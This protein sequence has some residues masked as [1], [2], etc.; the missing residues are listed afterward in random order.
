[1]RACNLGVSWL[2]ITW[3]GNCTLDIWVTT[4]MQTVS[5]LSLFNSR[6]FRYRRKTDVLLQR[7]SLLK[8]AVQLHHVTPTTW[9]S[10]IVSRCGRV[11]HVFV[12]SF[13]CLF[14]LRSWPLS[15]C[16]VRFHS[17]LL[18]LRSSSHH[19]KHLGEAF[20][21]WHRIIAPCP[22]HCSSKRSVCRNIAWILRT[23]STRPFCRFCMLTWCDF[24]LE[25]WTDLKLSMVSMVWDLWNALCQLLFILILLGYRRLLSRR[26]WIL[27]SEW[28]TV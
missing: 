20:L 15:C 12:C 16:I 14:V 9:H 22:G 3:F 7:T 28:T 11:E 4:G 1:M 10:V 23:N 13:V 26:T 6:G 5:G 21:S 19:F 2:R 27:S 24:W 25:F 8:G 18:C 17:F